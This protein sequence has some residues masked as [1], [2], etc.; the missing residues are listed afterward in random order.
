MQMIF[1]SYKFYFFFLFLFCSAICIAQENIK[2]E[3]RAAWIATYSNI[4]WPDRAQTPQQQRED[5]IKIIDHHKSTGIN[6]VYVQIRSQCDAM[7][8]STIEPWS[9]DLTGVQGM[10]PSP[11]W[12]PMQFMIAECHRRGIEFHAWLNP[13]RA[14]GK[15]ASL[16]SFTSSHVS[17][18]HPE[19]LLRSGTKITLNPG[20]PR[21]RD[22]IMSVITDIVNRYDVDGIHF[23]DYFYPEQGFNDN[24]AYAADPRGITSRADWRRDNVNLLIQRIYNE[25]RIVKPWVKFGISPSGIYRNSTD[26]AIGSPTNGLEHYSVLYA[27]SKKWLQEGWVDYIEP[28]IYWYPGQKGSD[29]NVLVPWWNKN[30]FGRHIYIGMAGYKVES[31]GNSPWANVRQIPN[32]VRVN[33]SFINENIK[34]EGFYN[35]SSMTLNL[36][37]FNDSL[38]NSFYRTPALIPTMPW[39]DSV[40]PQSPSGLSGNLYDGDSIVLNWGKTPSVV[41]E[42]DKARLYVVYRSL[43]PSVDISEAENIIAVTSDTAS[44]RDTLIVPGVTYY[45]AVTALDRLYNESTASNTIPVG[46]LGLPVTLNSILIRPVNEKEIQLDWTTAQEIGLEQFVIEKSLDGGYFKILTI[47]EAI[48]TGESRKYSLKDKVETFNAP[49]FYRLKMVDTAGKETYS[50]IVSQTINREIQ[51][52]RL[53]TR[54]PKGYDIRLGVLFKGVIEYAVLDEERKKVTWGKIKPLPVNTQVILPGTKDFAPGNYVI[55]VKYNNLQQN[56]HL[57]VP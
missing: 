25:I 11:L 35:T 47:I 40:A 56:I 29:Y 43:V 51:I 46:K 41:N 20:L 1:R 21:V 50:K 28:Q 18:K 49:V 36:L 2:R 34:G 37:G 7:Y 38:K 44:Y 4:D 33:R 57:L 5:F 22:H 16:S 9:A 45:Y 19:W 15:T 48:G 55:N 12:D 54:I 31:W 6:A 14:A 42:M 13:Y 23:D 39:R 24:A 17:K 30:A 26:P 27:D 52:V 32:Q 8:P 53:N 3:L 10:A